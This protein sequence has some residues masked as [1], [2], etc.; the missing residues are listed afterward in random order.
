MVQSLDCKMKFGK[1]G[2]LVS[3]LRPE[4][5]EEDSSLP[6]G[7]FQRPIGKFPGTVGDVKTIPN[8]TQNNLHFSCPPKLTDL[9]FLVPS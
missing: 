8:F 5:K 3:H 2:S 6:A 1:Q 7:E 9:G 4:E